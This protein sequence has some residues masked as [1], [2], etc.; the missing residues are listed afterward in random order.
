MTE[1]ARTINDSNETSLSDNAPAE[2]AVAGDAVTDTAVTATA[3]ADGVGDGS[4]PGM[5]R[6]RFDLSLI[7]I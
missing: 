1:N 4:Q 3:V 5:A 7:H 6:E 2:A